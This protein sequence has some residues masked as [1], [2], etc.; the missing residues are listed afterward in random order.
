[1]IR[2]LLAEPVSLIREGLVA[3]LGR[4]K[5]IDLIAV[6]RNGQ[7]VLPAARDSRPHVALLAAVLPGYEGIALAR[8]L[9]EALPECHCTILSKGRRRDVEQAIMAHV[10][11]FLAYDWPTEFIIKAI[12]HVAAGNKFIDPGRAICAL[13][14][15]ACPLTAREAEVL[16][17][18]AQGAPTS[19][20]ARILSLAEGT[21]RNYLSR[22]IAKTGARNRIDA[23]R[24]ADE[25]GW[26]P[27]Q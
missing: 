23:I 12:R 10:D 20:I 7:E 26:V 25:R 18:A 16:Q 8:A 2:I 27:P 11:G 17:T 19:E 3:V 13:N 14:H 9:H 5:D 15:S 21:V 24:I 4:E 6:V 1:M 22:A